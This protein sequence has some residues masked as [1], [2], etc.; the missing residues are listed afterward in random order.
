MEHFNHS[1][2]YA[3]DCADQLGNSIF[4]TGDVEANDIGISLVQGKSIEEVRTY[5]SSI[6]QAQIA[7]AR[8]K[9]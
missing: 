3:I 1:L 2:S 9:I 5:V 7:A 6:V 8:V 4:F